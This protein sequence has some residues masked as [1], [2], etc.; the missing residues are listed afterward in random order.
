MQYESSLFIISIVLCLIIL[1]SLSCAGSLTVTK[2]KSP[3]IGK[4]KVVAPDL[5]PYSWVEVGMD[6][7]F[8][9]DGTLI[10]KGQSQ[11]SCRF[12]VLDETRLEVQ[13][14]MWSVVWEFSI[15]GD[16]LTIKGSF[17][18]GEAGVWTGEIVT[19]SLKKE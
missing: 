11:E 1:F 5:G 8:L 2:P 6:L 14:S 16:E 7:E 17:P 13:T 3:L 9:N 12:R 18:T 10:I 19:V 15:L 4:W